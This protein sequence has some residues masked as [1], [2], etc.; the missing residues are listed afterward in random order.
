[1]ID[2]SPRPPMQPWVLRAIGATVVLLIC[3]S[4]ATV[5]LAA[6]GQSVLPS[7]FNLFIFSGLALALLALMGRGLADQIAARITA[8]I[9]QTAARHDRRMNN[10]ANGMIQHGILLEEITGEIPKTRPLIIACRR[11]DDLPGYER[12]YADGL[13]RAPMASDAKV[14]H[15]PGRN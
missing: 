2:P 7:P 15:L 8:H 6:S 3:Y 11:E 1:M 12:G 9:D 4:V 5:V 10:I 13:A 14:I